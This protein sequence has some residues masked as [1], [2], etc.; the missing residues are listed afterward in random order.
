MLPAPGVGISCWPPFEITSSRVG[1]AVECDGP[2]MLDRAEQEDLVGGILLDSNGDS[3]VGI[4]L[5]KLVLN[6][7]GGL[8]AS[9]VGQLDGA[10]EGKGDFRRR[11]R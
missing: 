7:V 10:G 6:G 9:L 5:G 2:G 4:E 11:G 1:R 8:S 3:G